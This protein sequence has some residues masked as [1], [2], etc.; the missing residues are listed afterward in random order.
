MY[1]NNIPSAWCRIGCRIKSEKSDLKWDCSGGLRSL[2]RK[3]TISGLT[4]MTPRRSDDALPESVQD[5]H[6]GSFLGGGAGSN[7]SNHSSET[8][9][10][11]QTVR[12]SPP[13]TQ[14]LLVMA[15]RQRTRAKSEQWRS[16]SHTRAAARVCETVTLRVSSTCDLEMWCRLCMR[17]ST[18]RSDSAPGQLASASETLQG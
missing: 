1:G 13:F 12:I 10:D 6:L 8:N 14:M 15:M 4:L 7:D 3:N 9:G 11:N 16:E 5:D 17:W 18:R 2:Y